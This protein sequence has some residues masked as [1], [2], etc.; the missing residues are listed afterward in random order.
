MLLLPHSPREWLVT[1]FMSIKSYQ[2]HSKP[3]GSFHPVYG[4]MSELKSPRP[5]TQVLDDS[6]V[7]SILVNCE[8][9]GFVFF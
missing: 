4:G 1:Q 3:P 6:S 9:S 7:A 2:A 5:R 8:P